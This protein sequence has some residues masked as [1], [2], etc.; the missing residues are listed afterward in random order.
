MEE[1]SAI[2][3][4][5]TQ[6]A[7]G[8]LF[9]QA[10]RSFGV[11]SSQP[12]VASRPPSSGL[13]PAETRGNQVPRWAAPRALGPR[14][15][16]QDPVSTLGSQSAQ[17]HPA[18]TSARANLYLHSHPCC[19]RLVHPGDSDFRLSA[20]AESLTSPAFSSS[21]GWDCPARKPRL[22]QHLLCAH[23]YSHFGPGSR[24]AVCLHKGL[25]I[26]GS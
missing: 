2:A 9:I 23:A 19:D 3:P 7:V 10:H 21:R 12:P 26:L 14:R 4:G 25:T 16:L 20:E 1:S 11:A 18:P 8:G 17:P 15:L 13:G 6:E 5:R 22:L 24:N